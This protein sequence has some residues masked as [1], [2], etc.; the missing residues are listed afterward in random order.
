M[1]S[2]DKVE[3]NAHNIINYVKLCMREKKLGS[4]EIKEYETQARRYDF[5]YLLQISQE[6]I[7]MMNKMD[8]QS[9]CTTKYI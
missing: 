3:K 9:G 5:N 1:Y 2:L 6:Y 8:D 4:T 7:D